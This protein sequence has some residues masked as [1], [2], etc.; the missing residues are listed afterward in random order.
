[1]TS[2]SRAVSRSSSGSNT[3]GSEPQIDAVALRDDVSGAPFL[4]TAVGF[5]L[6]LV[7]PFYVS[8]WVAEPNYDVILGWDPDDIP[9]DWTRIRRKY[10][11]LNWLRGAFTWAAFGCFLAAS[12]AYFA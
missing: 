10:F 5:A 8:R 12:Y 3:P 4:W 9:S 2:C 1:M 7:G 6:V 11:A